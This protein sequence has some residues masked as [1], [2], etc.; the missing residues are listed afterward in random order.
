MT[1]RIIGGIDIETTGLHVHKGDRIIEI[2]ASLHDLDTGEKLGA[3]EQRINPQR[4]IDPDA[5][6]IHHISFES[7]VGM[8]LWADVAPTV[9][10]LMSRCDY[11]VA[12][13][14]YGFDFEFILYELLRVGAPLPKQIL[15]IDTML[16]GRWATPDGAVPNLEALCFASGVAYDRTKAHAALYDVDVMMESFFRMWRRGFFTLPAEPY[17]LPPPP[18]AK[19]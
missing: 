1:R 4:A 15:G 13:N 7:L 5:E 3:W 17:K 12:H 9:S 2:A 19:K 16:Q 10:K 8:P 11:L 18:A 6:A 14:G